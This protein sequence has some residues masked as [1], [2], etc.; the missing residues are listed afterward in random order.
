MLEVLMLSRGSALF[1]S[2]MEELVSECSEFIDVP[3]Y[4]LTHYRLTQALIDRQKKGGVAIR[5]IVNH[6]N[7]LEGLD[8]AQAP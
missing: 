5:V 4:S 1:V 8:S 2:R 6:T 7:A 3:M